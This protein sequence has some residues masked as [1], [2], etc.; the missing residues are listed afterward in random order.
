MTSK[1]IFNCRRTHAGY[2]LVVATA[3]LLLF[4]PPLSGQNIAAAPRDV[5]T[6]MDA[7]R[8]YDGSGRYSMQQDDG[9]RS[10][11]GL[12]TLAARHG[13]K[14]FGD[15]VRQNNSGAVWQT[16]RVFFRD[17]DTSATMMRMT[18]NPHSDALSYFQGNWNA[19][20]STI[21]WLRQPETSNALHGPM[22][23]SVDGTNLRNVFRDT[24]FMRNLI[25]SPTDPDLCYAYD[26]N[27]SAVKAYRLS[28][29]RADHTVRASPGGWQM[30]ISPDGRFLMDRT[31][32]ISSGGRG[33]WISS[34]DG[35]ENFEVPANDDVHDS[36][37]FHPTQ[38]KV[39]FWYEEKYR[40]EGFVQCNFDGSDLVKVN[41]Q[42]DWNHGDMGLD[43]GVHADGGITRIT[44]DTWAPWEPLFSKPGVE[45]YDI[46]LHCN[47]YATWQPKDVLWAY[48]TR[49]VASP[50]VSELDAFAC[51][52]TP[53]GR[54][55]RYRICY[56]GLRPG[57]SLDGPSAS[58]DGTKVIFNSNMLGQ[59]AIYQAVTRLPER[60]RS[61]Q[62]QAQGDGGV[63]TWDS[64]AHHAE[65]TA[66]LVYRSE[67]SGYGFRLVAIK[68]ANVTNC[69]VSTVANDRPCFY[70][71]SAVEHSGL[72][73]GL[74]DELCV[75][76][77]DNRRLYLEAEDGQPN[78]AMWV[79]FH[80]TANDLHYLWQRKHDVEG[81]AVLSLKNN[82]LKRPCNVWC[83]LKGEEGATFDIAAGDHEVS[84]KTTPTE[85]WR[86]ARADGKLDVSGI[87]TLK[88]KTTRFGSSI[89][90]LY[91]SEDD[92]FQPEHCVRTV[93]PP[94]TPIATL[95]GK[96]RTPYTVDL[97]WPACRDPYFHHYNLYC[98][99]QADF[100][101][102]QA[103]IVASPDRNSFLDWG[104]QPGTAAYYRVTTVDRTGRESPPSPLAKVDMP[105]VA[106][107]KIREEFVEKDYVPGFA[108]SIGTFDRYA[109]WIRVAK[110]GDRKSGSFTVGID[111]KGNSEWSAAIDEGSDYVWVYNDPFGIFSLS[112]G[113]HGLKI[114]NSSG[115]KIEK[116]AI[117]NNL[118]WKPRGPSS[119]L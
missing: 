33:F 35:K 100:E 20:G 101:P 50:H 118:A 18:N 67:T 75:A 14:P 37:R 49:I 24:S 86:W 114:Q 47:S 15:L 66:Y 62:W 57:A 68:P 3:C 54:V 11:Q 13:V 43:R 30:K 90:C 72:E 110:T 41:V 88:L 80:G 115:L 55:N 79:A 70:A 98:S 29:S 22:A 109:I 73:S 9:V 112:P 102:N 32:D 59:V 12:S 71:V 76:G 74:S 64:A 21:V 106:T 48:A 2:P 96:A 39:M 40:S 89:D 5:A 8:P 46:P 60:P 53:D 7:Y 78:D 85:T 63:L 113:T 104:L 26:L 117:T 116:V 65:T 95:K 51:E 92:Q 10:V 17:V 31:S 19:D 36:F 27:N 107:G 25:C 16:E 34:V 61:V 105:S 93:W 99:Q 28:T 91:L 119:A 38:K 87:D 103:F 23:M 1:S 58:P 56:T 82:P 45:Y 94:P 108:F 81:S 77:D 111:G 84:V 52:P 83:R 44:G 6:R 42:F 69:A 4:P 97:T